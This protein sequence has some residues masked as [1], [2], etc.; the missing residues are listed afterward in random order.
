MRGKICGFTVVDLSR[1]VPL[2]VK[3]RDLW[4]TLLDATYDAFIP[5]TFKSTFERV[6]CWLSLT[7]SSLENDER[8][9]ENTKNTR[10]YL[11]P[12]SIV[13]ELNEYGTNGCEIQEEG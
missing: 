7:F 5:T 2:H 3:G 11:A 10:G 8:Q 13:H 1:R 9:Q 4:P 6:S 12:R